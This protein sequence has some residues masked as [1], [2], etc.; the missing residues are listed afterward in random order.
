MLEKTVEAALVKR[1]KELGG[2]AY[3]WTSPGRTGVPDRIVMIP[4]GKIIFVELKSPT[5]KL[6]VRQEREHDTIRSLGFEVIVINNV[7]DARAFTL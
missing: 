4:G 3:K 5:G 7:E 2:I 6:T 1:V